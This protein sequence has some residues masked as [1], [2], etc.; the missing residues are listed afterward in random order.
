M[1][2]SSLL[3]IAEQA[4]DAG[5]SVVPPRTDGSKAPLGSWRTFQSRLPYLQEIDDWYRADQNPGIGVVCGAVSG[6]LE[7]L[8][9]D[10]HSAYE[11]FIERAKETGLSELVDRV[12]AGYLEST[13][14]GRHWLWRCSEISGNTKLANNEDQEVLIETRGEGGYIIVAP[15]SG[16]IHPSGEPYELLQGSI[17]TITAITPEER[18]LLLDLA[19]S[20]DYVARRADLRPLETE[21]RPGDQ[22][23]AESTWSELL[24]PE[25]WA[26][27]YTRN[28][29]T[30]WRRPGKDIGIS[31]SSG[32]GDADLL[33]V[34]TTSTAFE[35]NAAYSKFGA[36]A[37]LH[38]Q[39]D[40]SAAAAALRADGFGTSTSIPLADPEEG[41]PLPSSGSFHFSS[42]TEL[43]AEPEEAQSWLWDRTLATSSIS[44]LVSRPKVGKSTLARSI[45]VAVATGGQLLGRDVA[46]GKILYLQF[47]A[48][49][50]RSELRQSLERA[51]VPLDDRIWIYTG[52]SVPDP[53]DALEAAVA[54]HRPSLV[55]I[56]T[57]IRWV[58]VSDANDYS[59]MSQITESIATV[60]RLSGAHIMMLH[61]AGKADRDAGDS[62]L[63]STAIFGGVDTLLAMRSREGLR[64]LESR[65]R[66]GDDMEETVLDL[67]LGTGLLMAAGS[68]EEV[69]QRDLKAAIMAHAQDG[70]TRQQIIDGVEGRAA[71]I[72]KALRQLSA[73]GH[74]ERL[75]AGTRADPTVFLVHD[76]PRRDDDRGRIRWRSL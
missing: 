51:A 8:D 59:I 32:L 27:I 47:S 12:E 46:P 22:F 45:A 1:T 41:S 35:G 18:E 6:N 65:Q 48:E 63:G 68:L 52:P 37:L 20:F 69:E 10:R 66:Y 71:L 62:V 39:G 2:A 34:F 13:P 24:V 36:Y 40:Y 61:H 33:Y 73:E 55:I 70:M 15:S 67:D 9:F 14:K 53:I 19:R 25:G 49:G 58:P 50:K 31:A 23:N 11:D 30:Y 5:I 44:I 26:E 75:G 38:H 74:L 64:T 4:L 16:S 72:S 3:T 7:A 57:L 56:D 17:D 29:I 28:G 60:A 54:Q 76:E 42:W 21:S 43:L